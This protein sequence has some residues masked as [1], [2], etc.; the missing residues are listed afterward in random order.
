[1]HADVDAL[2]PT[3]RKARDAN[4]IVETDE[5]GRIAFR[6]RHAL[7]RQ[8]VYDELLLFDARRTHRNILETLESF[9]AQGDHLEELA[10]H[11]WEARDT[12]KTLRYNERAADAAAALHALPEA[13]LGY[14]RALEAAT[15]RRDEARLL[16]RL[17]RITSLLGDLTRAIE[18]HDAARAAAIETLDF[19]AAAHLTRM[20]AADR[21]NSGDES[22]VAFGMAFLDRYGDRG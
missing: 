3:L 9:D 14:E 2:L 15:D 22:C 6:F 17:G 13:R 21:R 16:E 10:Y 8:A 20:S 5:A 18:I 4:L 12:E 19:D 7:T 1:M 11:A